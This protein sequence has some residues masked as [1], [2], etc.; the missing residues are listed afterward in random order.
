LENQ[1]GCFLAHGGRNTP[2]KWGQEKIPISKKFLLAPLPVI[3]MTFV[4]GSSQL[5]KEIPVK[6]PLHSTSK[7]GSPQHYLDRQY[8][9]T[10][11]KT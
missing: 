10:E 5:K 1:P 8:Y 2:K 7:W 9:D 3:G 4:G 6:E 11:K